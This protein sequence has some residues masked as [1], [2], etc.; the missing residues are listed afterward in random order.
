VN[1][2]P[3]PCG[4]LD[5]HHLEWMNDSLPPCGSWQFE[6]RSGVDLPAIGHVMS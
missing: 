2:S 6:Q 4:A 5:V 3:F 1:P